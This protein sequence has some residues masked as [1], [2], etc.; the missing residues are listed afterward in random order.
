MG[1]SLASSV[2]TRAMGQVVIGAVIELLSLPTF[3]VLMVWRV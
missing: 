2:N 3:R 1:I